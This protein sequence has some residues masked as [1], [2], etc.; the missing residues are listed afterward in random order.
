MTELNYRLIDLNTGEEISP[1]DA[2]R[3]YALPTPEHRIH[4]AEILARYGGPAVVDR[5]DEVKDAAG[6]PRF[7]IYI[8]GVE[9]RVNAD[10]E[11]DENY[12]R[13]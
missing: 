2:F 10:T 7:D 13:S 9:E 4:D 5:I 6:T 1:S 8:D 12:R 3:L 11:N